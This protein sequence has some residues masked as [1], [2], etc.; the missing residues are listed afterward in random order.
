MQSNLNLVVVGQGAAGLSAAL[1]A[2]EGARERNLDLT[3]TLVEKAA[4]GE[5]GGNTRWSPSYMRM[6]DVD[7]VEASFVH[8]MLA[9]TRFAGD[10]IYFAR[11]A[12]EAP[13]TVEW[14]ASH[15]VEF[16]RP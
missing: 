14:I 6:A 16:H 10:E 15:G 8:D 4:Q 2:A 13:A 7:K 5:A 1:S 9:A 11:L 12:Q 3:V